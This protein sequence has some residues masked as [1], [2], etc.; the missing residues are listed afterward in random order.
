[1]SV[2]RSKIVIV[3][4]EP[5]FVES[6]QT[7]FR[8]RYEILSTQNSRTATEMVRAEQPQLILLN[9][10]MPE[11]DGYHVLWQI[12]QNRETA[13]IP[14]IVVT[15]LHE[16]ADETK[17]LRMGAVDFITKP[18]H[19]E[20]LQARIDNQ[21]ELKRQKDFFKDLSY[22]DYLTKIPNRRSFN[23]ILEREYR[24]CRRNHSCLSLL[25]IDVD[26]FK[27]YN[28]IY[29]H[30]AGDR[31]LKRIVSAMNQQLR[32]PSDRLARFGGEEFACVLPETDSTGAKTLA[33]SLQQAILNLHMVHAEGIKHRV[34]VS[35]GIATSEASG[36]CEADQLIGT[37]DRYLY[38]AKNQGRN[39]ICCV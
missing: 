19:P 4:D 13:D 8:D 23:E 20:I 37:A 16:V 30:V 12:K 31:C 17:S 29:G 24:R 1:M 38:L 6:L 33:I 27:K 3:D 5:R 21:L 11:M 18:Y 35:I 14:I 2:D 15:G 22:E 26:H 34:T 10:N 28:D 7:L 32:R 25:M 9:L 39:T 36:G